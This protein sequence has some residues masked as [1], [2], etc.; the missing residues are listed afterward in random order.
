MGSGMNDASLLSSLECA[1]RTYKLLHGSVLGLLEKQG[2]EELVRTLSVFWED[3][4]KKW[5]VER[6]GGAFERV[7]GGRSTRSGNSTRT[8][9]NL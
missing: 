8:H 7:V 6:A 2:K 5:E 4:V 9:E 1:Y 3:W